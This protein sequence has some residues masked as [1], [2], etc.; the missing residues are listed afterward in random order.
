FKDWR[1]TTK[2][3]TF[4]A[5]VTLN[6]IDINRGNKLQGL[7][8]L[9]R[10]GAAGS[11]TTASG[12]LASN[13]VVTN[14]SLMVN[15]QSIIKAGDFKQ[16]QAENRIRFGISA[17]FGSNVSRFDGVAYL[18]MLSDDGRGDLESALDVRP[19]K[20]D[21]VQLFVD[22]NTAGNLSYTN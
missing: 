7:M 14:Y 12:K 9:T 6:P 3:L 17:A 16:L 18:D 5:Q 4:S 22:T 1:Q 8:M 13:L 15:G 10:D 2:Q 11:T 20:V 19:P 21:N